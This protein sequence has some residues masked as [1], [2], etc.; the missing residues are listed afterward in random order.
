MSLNTSKSISKVVYNNVEIP[1]SGSEKK[2]YIKIVNASP[3]AVIIASISNI[4]T[5]YVID[6]GQSYLSEEKYSI[7]NILSELELYVDYSSVSQT[8]F[9]MTTIQLEDDT[10]EIHCQC[11]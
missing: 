8:S 7:N 6:A 1:L 5:K 2:Y 9:T 4:I 11:A 3:D 10:I